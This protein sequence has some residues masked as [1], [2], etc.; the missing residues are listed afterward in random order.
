VASAAA[1]ASPARAAAG[2]IIAYVGGYTSA[3]RRAGGIY[4]Y[5]L[6]PSD[7]RL[8]HWKTLTA[9]VS[10]SSL[11][12]HPNKRF[13]YAVNEVSNFSAAR[14]GSVT[15]LAIDPATGD[16]RVMNV[17]T[18]GGGGPA[19]LSVDPSGKWVLVA[20][21]GGGSSAVLPILADGSLGAP[22]DVKRISGPLGPQP[23]WDAPP[24]SYAISG[25]DAPHAHMAETD[26]AGNYVFISDLGTDR[27][28]IYALDKATG[29]LTPNSQP[30]LQASPGAGPRHFQFHQNN[31]WAYAINEEASTM[32]LMDYDATRGTLNIRQ[33]VSSLPEGYAGTNY[34]SAILLSDDGNTLYGV[35]RLHN[36]IAVFSINGEGWMSPLDYVWTQ[37]DYPRDIGIEPNGNFMYALHSR[38]DNITSFRVDRATG[39]LRFTGQFLP[40]SNPSKIVF[41]TLS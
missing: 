14:D 34:P 21:Y 5:H 26:R 38:S 8:T 17:I 22:T 33:S 29:T 37:G 19:H 15:S 27:I 4:L 9:P 7:G 35:N 25:H 20:N 41:L 36:S 11:A 1:A 39:L 10:P 28:Y 13:M 18:S 16:L 31:R 32:L 3:P 24:G 40:V 12:I 6:N 30:F 23:A 2:D